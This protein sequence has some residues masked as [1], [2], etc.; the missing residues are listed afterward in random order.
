MGNYFEYHF[1]GATERASFDLQTQGTNHV[2]RKSGSDAHLI[3]VELSFLQ[4]GEAV[5]IADYADGAY[6]W[7]IR[8]VKP[9]GTRVVGQKMAPVTVTN[10]P[11]DQL[12]NPAW[13]VIEISR[14][15]PYHRLLDLQKFGDF[16]AVGIYRVILTYD[17]SRWRNAGNGADGWLGTFSSRAFTVSIKP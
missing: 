4:S 12:G 8:Y 10:V 11:N 16:S 13:K 5:K 17:S 15:Q 9:D 3:P 2:Y 14:G 6:F 7:S 1:E